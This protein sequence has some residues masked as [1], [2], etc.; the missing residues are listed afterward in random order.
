MKMRGEGRKI[1][2]I[3]ELVLPRDL[4]K[5]RES[6]LS[7]TLVKSIDWAIPGSMDAFASPSTA[8]L[9]FTRVQGLVLHILRLQSNIISSSIFYSVLRT[10][11]AVCCMLYNIQSTEDVTCPTPCRNIPRSTFPADLAAQW[12]SPLGSPFFFWPSIFPGLR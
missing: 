5:S 7:S 11:Y 2:E 8:P 12:P 1:K 6:R 4:I 10:L 3:P 9:L